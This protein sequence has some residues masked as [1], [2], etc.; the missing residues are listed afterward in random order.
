MSG[1]MNPIKSSIN[2]FCPFRYFSNF[3]VMD[4]I[5]LLE[6]RKAIITAECYLTE[7]Q[8]LYVQSGEEIP[9]KLKSVIEAIWDLRDEIDG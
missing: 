5:K 6:A 9:A 3:A 7:A 2:G 1:Y 4:A 8:V